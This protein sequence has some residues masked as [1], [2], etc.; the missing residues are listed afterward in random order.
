V[1]AIRPLAPGIA[2]QLQ[3]YLDTISREKP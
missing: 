2:A 3:G 1:E